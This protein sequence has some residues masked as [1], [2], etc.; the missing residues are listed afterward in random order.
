MKRVPA[1]L[2]GLAFPVALIAIAQIA[3]M[4]VRL[5]SDTLASPAA[6]GEGRVPD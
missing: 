5:Q 6:V 3:A 1:V 2:R 4:A